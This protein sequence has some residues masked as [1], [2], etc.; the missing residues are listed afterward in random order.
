[1]TG[2]ERVKNVIAGETTDRLV[3][4]EIILPNISVDSFYTHDDR[5]EQI[6]SAQQSCEL[7]FIVLQYG[8]SNSASGA[9]E[10]EA[11]INTLRS[12]SNCFIFAGVPG[13]F[14][15]VIEKYEFANTARLSRKNPALY[16][17]EI[18]EFAMRH[19]AL[20]R[21]LIRLGVDGIFILDD[22]AGEQGLIFSPVTMRNIVLPGLR[23]MV[24][25]IKKEHRVPVFLHSDGKL[26]EV[27]DDLIAT[28]IDG[29]HG[30]G[31]LSLAELYKLKQ[32]KLSQVTVMGN[33]SVKDLAGQF[34]DAWFE[35]LAS[36]R[37]HGGY[38]FASDGGATDKV[39]WAKLEDL[40]GILITN[41]L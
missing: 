11:I 17:S 37:N 12:Q 1:M 8:F 4:G 13:V 32:G 40:H 24:A 39:S 2:Y 36:L 30:F 6:L 38:I 21:K 7:D 28:G 19:A 31:D 16:Q 27:L 18:E 3:R 26:T 34:D 15:P 33:I 25:E 5:L 22:L 41:G 14:W 20:A 29:I 10:N 9:G 35:T 23:K